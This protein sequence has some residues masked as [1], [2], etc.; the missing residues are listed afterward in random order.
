MMGNFRT[1]V[2]RSSLLSLEKGCK[3]PGEVFLYRYLVSIGTDMS[4]NISCFGLFMGREDDSRTDC[5]T[6][7]EHGNLRPRIFAWFF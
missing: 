4:L 6:Y 1:P 2:G 7:A 5:F 3:G